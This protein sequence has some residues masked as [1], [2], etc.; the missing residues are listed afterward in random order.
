[1]TKLTETIKEYASKGKE[2][3]MSFSS[4]AGEKL[5]DASDTVIKNIDTHR[6]QKRKQELYA[7]L[8]QYVYERTGEGKRLS[9]KTREAEELIAELTLVVDELDGRGMKAAEI[10]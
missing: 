10:E 7:D 8:G 6:L 2:T 3:L 5:Q 1:M 4:K 9:L